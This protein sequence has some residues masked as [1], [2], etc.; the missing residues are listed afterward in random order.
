MD[1]HI[2]ETASWLYL[3][4]HIHHPNTEQHEVHHCSVMVDGKNFAVEHFTFEGKLFHIVLGNPPKI[5]EDHLGNKFI[6]EKQ[7][8]DNKEFHILTGLAEKQEVR[9]DL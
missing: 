2:S 5:V 7:V 3:L 9:Y 6:V 8:L 1:K 4:H